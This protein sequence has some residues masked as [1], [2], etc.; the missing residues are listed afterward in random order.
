MNVLLFHPI[1]FPLIVSLNELGIEIVWLINKPQGSFSF[2]LSAPQR[3]QDLR[4]LIS[5]TKS[6]YILWKSP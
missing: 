1:L 6:A 2:Y 5:Q 4:M 3:P